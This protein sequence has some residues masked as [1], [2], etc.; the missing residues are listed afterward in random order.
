MGAG[1]RRWVL[2]AQGNTHTSKWVGGEIRGWGQGE[3][4]VVK[5]RQEGWDYCLVHLPL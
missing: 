4:L 5:Q 3:K 2:G 1:L